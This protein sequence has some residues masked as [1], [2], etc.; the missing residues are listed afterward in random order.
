LVLE[1]GHY[2]GAG[3]RWAAVVRLFLADAAMILLDLI[4]LP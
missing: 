2:V 3:L 1:T 4:A